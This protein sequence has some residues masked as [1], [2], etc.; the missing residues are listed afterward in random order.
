MFM[1][2]IQRIV[3]YDV[4]NLKVRKRTIQEAEFWFHRAE[5]VLDV[6]VVI[7]SFCSI[8]SPFWQQ[9][10]NFTEGLGFRV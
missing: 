6:D 1:F 5:A 3:L 9:T 2:M 4:A 7:L 8:Q 10:A